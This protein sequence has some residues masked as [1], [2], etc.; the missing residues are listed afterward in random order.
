MLLVSDI[1]D[2]FSLLRV[3]RH[4]WVRLDGRG[5]LYLPLLEQVSA[6]EWALG[7]LSFGLFCDLFPGFC[8]ARLKV[9]EVAAW[10]AS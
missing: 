3:G 10:S 9:D 4:D 1:E 6:E 8:R 5:G 2:S 7:R